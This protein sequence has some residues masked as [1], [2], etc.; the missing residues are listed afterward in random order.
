MHTTTNGLETVT[1]I[2]LPAVDQAQ[3]ADALEREVQLLKARLEQALRFDV[4]RDAVLDSIYESAFDESL[5]AD[6]DYDALLDRVIELVRADEDNDLWRPERDY[7][8]TLSYSVTV[9]GTIRARS[10]DDAKDLVADLDP[11]FSVSY[12]GAPDE[13]QLGLDSWD[14]DSSEV[15]QA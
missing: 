12:W 7:D 11:S 14:L 8:V 5:P 9:S 10:Q 2:L 6:T 3:R 1:S 15:E 13:S 4:Q